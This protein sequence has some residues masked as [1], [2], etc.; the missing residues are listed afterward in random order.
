MFDGSIAD[1]IRY[2]RP[3]ATDQ[4]V[5]EAARIAHVDEFVELFE[6]NHWPI[7]REQLRDRRDLLV[8]SLRSAAGLA[9][10][11]IVTDDQ[12]NIAVQAGAYIQ[13]NVYLGVQAGANAATYDEPVGDEPDIQFVDDL[14]ERRER[15][16]A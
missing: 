6:R 1:N 8:D 9:D 3:R 16:Q 5:M 4:E 15:D 2:G 12:G 14:D 7:L 11:D 13:D 10:L